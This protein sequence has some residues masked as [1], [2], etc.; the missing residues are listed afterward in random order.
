MHRLFKILG[1]I[2]VVLIGLV[3]ILYGFAVCEIWPLG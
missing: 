1:T 2:W 3:I